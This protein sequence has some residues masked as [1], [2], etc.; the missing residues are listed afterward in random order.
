MGARKI[1]R[2]ADAGYVWST[3]YNQ[4]ERYVSFPIEID[5]E[6]SQAR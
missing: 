4:Y 2:G 1:I 5:G 6:L 3:G